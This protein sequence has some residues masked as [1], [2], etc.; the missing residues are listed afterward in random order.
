MSTILIILLAAE[1]AL[2]V[3]N[4]IFSSNSSYE[5]VDA[6][7]FTKALELRKSSFDFNRRSLMYNISMAIVLAQ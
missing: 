1:N 4:W 6:K 7:S 5:Y 3:A 2:A